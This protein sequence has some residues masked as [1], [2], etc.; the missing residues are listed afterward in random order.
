MHNRE[1]FWSSYIQQRLIIFNATICFGNQCILNCL[2][3]ISINRLVFLMYIFYRWIDDKAIGCQKPDK[4][5]RLD[6]CAGPGG[7]AS[8]L[9]CTTAF[10]STDATHVKANAMSLITDASFLIHEMR[11]KLLRTDERG[12]RVISFRP[13]V[14]SD[15]Y[16]RLAAPTYPEMQYCYSPTYEN[17]LNNKTVSLLS[18]PRTKRSHYRLRKKE[19][20]QLNPPVPLTKQ[21]ASEAEDNN[22]NNSNNVSNNDAK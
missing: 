4:A 18:S 14:M 12:E 16:I 7:G 5:G 13:T 17:Y 2:V 8:L 10:L 9:S 11:I 21:P 6:F 15:D 1:D 3:L 20:M 22:N 19:N